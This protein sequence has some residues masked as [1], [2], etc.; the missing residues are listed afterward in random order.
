MKVFLNEVC[1]SVGCIGL[2]GSIFFL[3]A[4]AHWEKILYY[5]LWVAMTTLFIGAAVV[6]F[7]VG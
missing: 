6:L 2:V 3:C 7:L 4:Y 5:V 1:F